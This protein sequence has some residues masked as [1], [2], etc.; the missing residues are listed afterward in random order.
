[1][2]TDADYAPCESL[3]SN[4]RTI[5]G[6]DADIWDAIG[7]KLGLK[8]TPVATNFPGIVSGVESGRYPVAVSCISDS[9][10]REHRVIFV[11]YMYATGAIYA[12]AT[13][14]KVTPD[15]L[16]LCGLKT[17]A[18][19][20]TDTVPSIL[21]LSDHCV[22]HGRRSIGLF[23][24]PSANAMFSALA[25]GRVDFVVNDAVAADAMRAQFPVR[26]KVIDSDMLPKLYVG[27]I[28]DQRSQPL[29]DALLAA[30]K[31]IQADGTYGRILQRWRL[32]F[33]ALND[34]GLN[35]ATRRPLPE[36]RP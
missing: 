16:S 5:V 23:Q 3:S 20:G 19:A 33:L 29:A 12:L 26:L 24:F 7:A 21:Q 35:L 2:A 28:V 18:E 30:V 32:N 13:N 14:A 15:S 17:A 9:A 8:V 1:M 4:G 34:P 6:F 11:D 27:M 22:R 36:P 31:S 10:E 25:S